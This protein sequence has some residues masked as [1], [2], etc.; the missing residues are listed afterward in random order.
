MSA[1]SKPHELVWVSGGGS[2]GFEWWLAVS[3]G[4]VRVVYVYVYGGCV[5]V[6]DVMGCLRKAEG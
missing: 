4:I 1:S 6:V 3:V 5:I 2:L